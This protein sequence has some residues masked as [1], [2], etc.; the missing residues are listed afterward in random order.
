M[1][2]MIHLPVWRICMRNTNALVGTFFLLIYVLMGRAT[3]IKL[4]WE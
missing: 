4:R 3:E 1:G 2:Y